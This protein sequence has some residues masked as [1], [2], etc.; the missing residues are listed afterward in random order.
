MLQGI[1]KTT[2]WVRAFLEFAKI[3][4]HS[5]TWGRGLNSINNIHVKDVASAVL[6]VLQAALEHRAYEGAEGSCKFA[7]S[8]CDP[9]MPDRDTS[10][11][12]RLYR[13]A[14]SFVV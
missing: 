7:H 4:G 10:F 9:L 2:V 11:R 8:D 6:I 13:R 1:Q 3:N 5:G 12:F 14:E